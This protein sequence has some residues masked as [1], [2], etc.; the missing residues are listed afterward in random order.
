MNP[1][2]LLFKSF[3]TVLKIKKPS[4]KRRPCLKTFL[5]SVVFLS[6]LFK[7]SIFL[8]GQ[9]P[10]FFR[11]SSGQNVP[12]SGGFG[13]SPKTVGPASFPCFFVVC[14][15]HVIN[16]IISFIFFQWML[17]FSVGSQVFPR[18]STNLLFLILFSQ[19]F[20]L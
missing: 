9:F 13:S 12:S 4:L 5:M 1:K 20:G 16:L 18:I 3:F 14:N 10:P 19:L 8:N 17:F 7:G 6:R 11:S 15:R 2:R